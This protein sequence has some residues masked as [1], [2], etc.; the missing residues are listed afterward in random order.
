PKSF[1]V[2]DRGGSWRRGVSPEDP[3]HPEGPG[4][5]VALRVVAAAEGDA[6]ARDPWRRCDEPK[7]D[8]DGG[9]D[10]GTAVRDGGTLPARDG[11]G[12][13]GRQ[14]TQ[15]HTERPGGV[16]E[17]HRRGAAVGDL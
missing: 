14:R 15:E 6:L 13:A 8:G 10:E 9:Q 5:D 7:R 11:G 12:D 3:A 4:F 16:D 17:G 2:G 1:S